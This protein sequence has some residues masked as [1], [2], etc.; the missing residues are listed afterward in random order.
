[1]RCILSKAAREGTEVIMLVRVAWIM[2]AESNTV[3]FYVL[4]LTSYIGF[5]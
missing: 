2:E 4:S 1:M 3:S 5:P